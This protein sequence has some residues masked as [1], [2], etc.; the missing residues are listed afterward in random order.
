MDATNYRAQI[1]QRA[2]IHQMTTARYAHL[3]WGACRS[4]GGIRGQKYYRPIQ[5]VAKPLPARHCWEKS[6][7]FL[8]FGRSVRLVPQKPQGVH[9]I[10]V[11]ERGRQPSAYLSNV[12]EVTRKRRR[13]RPEPSAT[14]NRHS[15]LSPSLAMVS[16]IMSEHVPAASS[17]AALSSV[18]SRDT[19]LE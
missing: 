1:A 15:G 3:R 4:Y 14:S 6:A 2:I 17:Q 9:G 18:K 10:A 11:L 7:A 12:S 19:S 5:L 13:T 16:R 8:T